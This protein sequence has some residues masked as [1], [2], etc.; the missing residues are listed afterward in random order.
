M[1]Q[2][3]IILG[4]HVYFVREG[5][6]FTVPAAGTAG[7]NSKPGAADV[8]WLD[9]GIL[10]DVGMTPSA[11]LREIMAPTPG[12]LRLYDVIPTAR[13][14]EIKMAL[15]EMSALVWELLF[16]TLPLAAGANVQYN[17]N[18]GA[19]KKGWIK[20]QQYNGQNDALVNT[21]D[22]YVHL[23]VDGEVK[24]DDNVVAP[25]LK[26]SVLHSTLNTGTLA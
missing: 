14:L 3:S 24:F 4:S 21:A 20:L 2:G 10:K 5:D 19:A 7:R 22:L 26:A 11:Q 6:A 12:V 17:P 9:L 25:N 8:A 1:Q 23:E 15:Q 13:K 16:S 18:A